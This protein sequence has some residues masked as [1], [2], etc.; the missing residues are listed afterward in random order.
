[1]T[2]YF[3]PT[4]RIASVVTRWGVIRTHSKDTVANHSF[5]VTTY[6]Q[7]IAHLIDWA[8]DNNLYKPLYWLMRYSLIHDLDELFTGDLVT[9]IKPEIIDQDRAARY[10][11]A[12]MQERMPGIAAAF[13]EIAE[14]PYADEIKRIVKVADW[15]DALF[16]SIDEQ[17]IGNVAIQK[18][19]PF[20][21][22][23][24]KEAWFKL[25]CDSARLSDLWANEMLAAIRNHRR[26]D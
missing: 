7:D 21:L 22:D 9:F 14:L 5:Y 6:A 8:P 1:M 12:Q 20:T 2:N 25:P 15:L 3:P 16:F 18:Y 26:L 17:K 19:E 10:V 11:A 4:L 24:L 23:K 13:T